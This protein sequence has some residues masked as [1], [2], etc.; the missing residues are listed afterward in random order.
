MPNE[1]FSNREIKE[2]FGELC[3]KLDRIE[4]QT[5]KINGRVSSLEIWKG[6]IVGGILVLTVIV[7]PLLGWALYTL[8][9]FRQEVQDSTQVALDRA[10]SAYEVKVQ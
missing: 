1:P 9:T 7:I 8:A 4:T 3:S 10:L 5:Q 6:G 2:M